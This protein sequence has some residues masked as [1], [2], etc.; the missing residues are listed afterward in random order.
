[1]YRKRLLYLAQL[2]AVGLTGYYLGQNNETIYTL[3]NQDT[4]VVD[5]RRLKSVPGLPVFGTVSA[6]TPYVESGGAKDRV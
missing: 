1:M 5:G 6:A 4:I 2:S 3:F